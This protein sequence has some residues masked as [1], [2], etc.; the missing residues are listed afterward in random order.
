MYCQHV[1][2]QKPGKGT[3]FILAEAVKKDGARGSLLNHSEHHL[4]FEIL[5]KT[6]KRCKEQKLKMILC[7]SSLKEV[8]KILKL[9][10][11]AVAF[12]IKSLIG[13]GEAISREKPESVKKF[14]ELVKRFNKK[15]KT[16]ILALCGAGI[17]KAEDVKEAL[18]LGCV[19]VL[20][21]S[22]VVKSRN[23]EKLLR[24][25]LRV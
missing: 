18:R 19:G 8:K 15:N 2:F 4:R 10:P 17:S 12:E 22:A 24:E 1:D 16:R 21:A 9:K 23:P 11:E 14:A 13:T 3:G 20:V 6:A 5:K 25:M 7:A